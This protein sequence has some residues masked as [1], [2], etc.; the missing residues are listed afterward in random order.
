MSRDRRRNTVEYRAFRAS[1]LEQARA[2]RGP[3]LCL[4]CGVAVDLRLPA[5]APF[6]P[7]VDHEPPLARLNGTD[8]PT[9][10]TESGISHRRCNQSHG[11]RLSAELR[12]ERARGGPEGTALRRYV[13]ETLAR[14]YLRSL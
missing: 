1:I 7:T 14:E 11:G 5:T 8:Y 9:A 2:Q 10:V 13:N 12:K 6:G 3:V 4:R